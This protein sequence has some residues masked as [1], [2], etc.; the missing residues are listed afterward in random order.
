VVFRYHHLPLAWF[1]DKDNKK[2]SEEIKALQLLGCSYSKS[3]TL[4]L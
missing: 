1:K 2:A 4:N 3:L